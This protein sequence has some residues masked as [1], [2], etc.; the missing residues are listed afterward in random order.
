MK[1]VLVVD[2]DSD[3]R[4]LISWKLAQAGYGTPAEADGEAALVAAAGLSST[5]VLGTCP[6]LVLLDW[7]MPKMSGIDVCRALRADPVTADIP[8]ILLTAKA[9]ESEVER[10]FAA[11]ADDYIVKPFSPREMLRRVE[12][13]LTRAE[14]QG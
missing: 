8:V 3:I 6:D 10:G 5:G 11:G 14:V 2:D 13:L 4:E 1:T 9:Q 12:A 7:T